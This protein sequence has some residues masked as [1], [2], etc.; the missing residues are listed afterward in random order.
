M[1]GEPP[2]LSVILSTYNAPD[3]L[4]RALWGYSVQACPEFEVVV[5]DDGVGVG[6]SVGD[7]GPVVDVRHAAGDQEDQRGFALVGDV[8]GEF[9]GDL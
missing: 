8:E 1:S 7:G 5:A 9:G 6:Q 4:E 2:A 3:E